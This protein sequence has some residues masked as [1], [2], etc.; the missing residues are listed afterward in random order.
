VIVD[1]N[2]LFFTFIL[3]KSTIPILPFP[4]PILR[5]TADLYSASW[6]IPTFQLIENDFAIGPKKCGGNAQYIQKDRWLHHT[7][8]L[9]D[10]RNEN[11][12]Y[13]QLPAKR[14]KYRENRPHNDFLCRLK[15]HAPS[16][17][18]L[19]DQLKKELGKRFQ[20][21][22]VQLDQLSW[23]PHREQLRWVYC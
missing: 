17:E 4:E 12:T 10:Y 3:N 11:M 14:P 1:E 18:A 7:S 13:L 5:W 2:T 15:D 21:S 16:K 6:Q 20:V 9:W 22:P 19:I 23:Q 8:F